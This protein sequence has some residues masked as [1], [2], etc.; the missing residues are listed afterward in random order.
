M[1]L[2]R[3]KIEPK[4]KP[5]GSPELDLSFDMDD[6]I[7]KVGRPICSKEWRDKEAV[8]AR[9]MQVQGFSQS[10]IAEYLGCSRS[11]VKRRLE[12]LRPKS[13]WE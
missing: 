6:A 5:N 9:E 4:S 10:Q 11:T 1:N 13:S 2:F 12:R 3:T 8:I 7:Q